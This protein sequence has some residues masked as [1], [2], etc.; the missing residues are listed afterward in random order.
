MA[1]IGGITGLTLF[2]MQFY[3]ADILFILCIVILI[4]GVISS[5]RLASGSH[6]LPQLL[7]GYFLGL[8]LV[9]GLLI[10]IAP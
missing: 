6:T 5:A 4:T 8:A 3:R 2:L 10:K 7:A 1:G 9:F